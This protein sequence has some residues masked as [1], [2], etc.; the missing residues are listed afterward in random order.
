MHL[1]NLIFRVGRHLGKSPRQVRSHNLPDAQRQQS[2]LADA[3]EGRA[4]LLSA[5][6]KQRRKGKTAAALV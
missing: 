6:G 5:L 2:N 4:V 1:D 3:R